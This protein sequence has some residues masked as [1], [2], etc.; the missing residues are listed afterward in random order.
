MVANIREKGHEML[1]E[2]PEQHLESVVRLLELVA[3]H[4]DNKDVE[5]EELWS[6]ASGELEKMNDEIKDAQPIND[7]RTY[8]DEI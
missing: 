7:W 8:L 2:I 6:L 3:K 1:D 5:P 4:G